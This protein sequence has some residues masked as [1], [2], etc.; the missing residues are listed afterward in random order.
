ML[1][2]EGL[3]MVLDHHGTRGSHGDLRRPSRHSTL[4][5]GIR[6]RSGLALTM[7]EPWGQ[8]ARPPPA[9]AVTV[10][11]SWQCPPSTSLS[12]AAQCKGW[13]AT[14][15]QC[16]LFLNTLWGSALLN[17]APYWA[18]QSTKPPE[19][20]TPSA[21]FGNDGLYPQ[22]SGHWALDGA[23]A[24]GMAPRKHHP[25]RGSPLPRG[26]I[27]AQPRCG[28]PWEP[29]PHHC[30]H[31]CF[32]ISCS[33]SEEQSRAHSTLCR[34]EAREEARY[35]L[36]GTSQAGVLQ[37]PVASPDRYHLHSVCPPSHFLGASWHGLQ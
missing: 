22:C 14:K 34:Q 29:S 2:N 7:A 3:D 31:I 35:V 10:G 19:H 18:Y 16:H 5:D 28:G 17:L 20:Q 25:R 12:T 37:D 30:A 24:G 11:W 32:I 13:H 21:Q 15:K 27:P 9:F 4:T 26:V 36:L 1:V 6:G 8:G 33:G 23:L